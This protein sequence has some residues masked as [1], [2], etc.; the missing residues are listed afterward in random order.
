MEKMIKE[1]AE[2]ERL[3]SAKIAQIR[4]FI[5]KNGTTADLKIKLQHLYE[6][7][8]D[9][10]RLREYLQHYYEKRFVYGKEKRV[11]DCERYLYKT[12]KISATGDFS[13]YA[14][15]DGGAEEESCV[16]DEE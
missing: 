9:V 6:A 12:V 10:R 11:T 15:T 8:L 4:E 1:Y 2:A 7:R 13:R 5:K 16:G 14:A 3:L